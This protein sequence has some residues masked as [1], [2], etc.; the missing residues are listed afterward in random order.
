MLSCRV[1]VPTRDM[2]S[3]F[4]QYSMCI[5]LTAVRNP[6]VAGKLSDANLLQN[7][8]RGDSTARSAAVADS[9]G[10]DPGVFRQATEQFLVYLRKKA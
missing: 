7:G 9:V 3:P 6:S 4:P 5:L 1:R 10:N 2:G 8:S